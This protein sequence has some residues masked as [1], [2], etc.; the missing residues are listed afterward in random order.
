MDNKDETFQYTYSAAQQQE[1]KRIRSKYA[2]PEE[3]KMEELRRLD[4]S[5]TQKAQVWALCLGVIGALLLGTGM[6]L[7]MTDLGTLLGTY[8]NGHNIAMPAGIAIGIAGLVL[9]AL[10]YPLYTRILKRERRRIAP[11]I[12]HLTNELMQ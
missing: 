1:I 2:P 11:R 6:S 4:R 9:A 10:A 7:A 8:W 5:A 3:N 12:L